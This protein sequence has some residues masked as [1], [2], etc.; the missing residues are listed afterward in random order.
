MSFGIGNGNA[1]AVFVE[2]VKFGDALAPTLALNYSMGQLD[3][4]LATVR[5]G[6]CELTIDANGGADDSFVLITLDIHRY[7]QNG[8][9]LADVQYN[10][11][12]VAAA[13]K[14]A[15][16]GSDAAGWTAKAA[17]LK[18]AIDLLNEV[19]GIQAWAM[20]APHSMCM[21]NNNFIDS[22]V[23]AIESQ[24]GR[25]TECLYRDIDAYLINTDRRVAWMRVGLPEMRDAGSMKLLSV[26]GTI[27][28]ATSG[29]V[30]VYRDDIRD[31]GKEYNATYAT[32]AALK[33][34]FVDKTGVA[35]TQTEY[36]DGAM[37]NAETIQGPVIVEVSATD[38]TATTLKLKLMQAS[39]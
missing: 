4:E 34:M 11:S 31:Y 7:D 3:D 24:P 1:N 9:A 37:D 38:I 21:G 17:T 33:Q 8:D 6:H 32:E 25:Y 28:G 27:T 16:A 5:M 19:P 35:T 30:R 18:E 20:H 29:V 15:W 39:F 13:G 2:N 22:A 14:V 12:G 23:A 36:V 10:L 26:A